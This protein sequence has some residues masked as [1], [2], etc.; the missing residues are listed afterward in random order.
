MLQSSSHRKRHL[1]VFGCQCAQ[2]GR[3]TVQT[4][5]R[6]FLP[7]REA[8]HS[9]STMASKFNLKESDLQST[10]VAFE[11]L[12]LLRTCVCDLKRPTFVLEWKNA[13]TSSTHFS[14]NEH[15]FLKRYIFSIYHYYHR[16]SKLHPL[17]FHLC[18]CVCTL[19]VCDPL[20]EASSVPLNRCIALVEVNK[21]SSDPEGV[22]SN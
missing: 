1:F 13:P 2:S 10:R 21:C 7:P 22:P 4:H 11:S 12:L 3:D 17:E 20:Y 9:A 5:A 15:L 14:E 18:E 6:A 19:C 8:A 16:Q